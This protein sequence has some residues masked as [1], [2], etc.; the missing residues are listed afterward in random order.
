MRRMVVVGALVGVAVVIVRRLAPG[1]HERLMAR[2]EGMFER[3]PDTFPP[4]RVMRG[5]DEIRATTARIQELVEARADEMAESG[6]S[7]ADASAEP[8]AAK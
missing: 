2:C 1:L 5:I 6:L 8:A 7:P 3:M 4:K